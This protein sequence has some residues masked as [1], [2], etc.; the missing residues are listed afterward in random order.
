MPF[1]TKEITSYPFLASK[2][3]S[4]SIRGN[5][6]RVAVSMSSSD[7]R[8]IVGDPDEIL[9]LYEPVIKSGK[10]IGYTYW[11]VIRRLV[12]NGSVSEKKEAL[13]RISFNLDDRV[14]RV[15]GWGLD[16]GIKKDQ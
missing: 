10:L 5:Y 6:R 16:V 4:A 3:R 14:S 15:D 7:V 2:E 13:V 11:Y 1:A 9:P 12:A 8:V